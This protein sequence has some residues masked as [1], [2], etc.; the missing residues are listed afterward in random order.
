[1]PKVWVPL[2]YICSCRVSQIWRLKLCR[3]GFQLDEAQWKT[4]DT[5]EQTMDMHS[6]DRHKNITIS[7]SEYN[8]NTFVAWPGSA[9]RLKCFV[10]FLRWVFSLG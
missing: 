3:P 6:N 7:G 10:G 4:A 5:P 8:R 2:D 9:A 1:M